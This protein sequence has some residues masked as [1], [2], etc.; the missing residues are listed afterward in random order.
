MNRK[1]EEAKSRLVLALDVMKRDLA[2][3]IL[4]KVAGKV[5][6]IKVNA[7][8]ALYP[9]IIPQI[10][11]L[12]FK[13]WRDWKHHDIPDT[14]G[15]FIKADLDAGID[16]TT[17]HTL[18]GS[19]TMKKA[20][21]IAVAAGSDL[22]ILGITILTSHDQDSFNNELGIPGSIQEKVV[23]LALRAE[24]AGLSGVVASAIEAPALRRVLKQE[25][26]IVTPGINP[27]WAVKHEDQARVTTPKQAILNGANYIVV[28]SAIYK[29]EN[30]AEAA[31]K[32]VDEIAE[33]LEELENK[34]ILAETGA[35]LTDQHF[36][37]TSGKHGSAYVNKDAVYPHS[38]ETSNLCRTIAE[39]FADS[40]AEVVIAPA[41]GGTILSQW[42]A[43]HLSE[44]CGREILSVYAEKEGESFIIKR[45][46]DK[47]IPKRKVLVVEDVLTTGGSAK[48]VVEVTRALGGN[49]VG[50]GV[51][52]NR[53]GV[54]P[55]DVA[56]VPELFALVNVTLDAW[57]E[58]ECP[59]CKEGIPI[60]IDVGKGREWLKTENGRAYAERVGQ[61]IP[62]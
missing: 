22:K 8:A 4:N 26:L 62:E 47:L 54:R 56:D 55:E 40:G 43:Y 3:E 16:I 18:G 36:V 32:I 49:V 6:I 28:G 17:I 44:L 53:G 42:V 7:L 15:N 14:V 11:K 33:A 39:H 50:L 59:L 1:H 52:C 48:K 10:K 41:I 31:D 20:V 9:D 51:I 60:N 25:T 12:G 57:D 2:D 29:N 27:L 61:K 19:K 35:V 58:G 38:K 5:G 24:K 23:N 34:G 46:Y 13:V 37:Y 30:P 21:E 45:G